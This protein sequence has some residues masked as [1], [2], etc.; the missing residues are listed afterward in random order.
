MSFGQKYAIILPAGCG[1][2]TL[3]KKYV[4]LYDIDS[5]L[6]YSQKKRITGIMV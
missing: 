3:A 1:K 6:S 4:R 5:F 2:S